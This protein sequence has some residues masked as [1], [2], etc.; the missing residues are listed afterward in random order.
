MSI[1][2]QFAEAIANGKKRYEYR[3]R[4]FARRVDT[5]VVYAT[6]PVG[7]AIGEFDVRDVLCEDLD[8]LWSATSVHGGIDEEY[9]RTYFIG[10]KKGYAIM[11]G[12]FRKYSKP[13]RIESVLGVR[14]PQSFLYI[15]Q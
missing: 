1:K 15:S 14:P 11:I 12:K 3:R 9:F 7:L 10:K 6:R 13:Y 5:I 2:P 8:A 4:I